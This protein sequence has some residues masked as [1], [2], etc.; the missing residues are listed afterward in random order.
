[1]KKCHGRLLL[2]V[3]FLACSVCFVVQLRTTCPESGTADSELE[4][5]VLISNKENAP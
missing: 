4:F 3:L 5:P 2:A 1:M